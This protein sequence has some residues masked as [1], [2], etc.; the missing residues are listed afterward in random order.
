MCFNF[1]HAR[2][3]A[4]LNCTALLSKILLAAVAEAADHGADSAADRPANVVAGNLQDTSD[5]VDMTIG[6]CCNLEERTRYC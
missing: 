5:Q 3:V 1:N 2:P 6:S 4:T